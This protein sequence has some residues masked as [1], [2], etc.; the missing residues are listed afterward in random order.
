MRYK[1][2]TGM[3]AFVL[4]RVTGLALTVYLLMH[5]NVVSTLHNPDSFDKTMAFLNMP[6]FKILEIGLLLAVIYHAL[7]GVRVFLID[8]TNSTRTHVKI[9]WVL[10]AIGFVIFVVGAYPFLHHGGIL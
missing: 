8:F 3:W 10:A 6:L 9:W 5:I 4:H 1:W 2:K 7:N